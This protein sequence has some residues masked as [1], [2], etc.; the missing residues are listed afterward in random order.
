MVFGQTIVKG[1]NEG[2]QAFIVQVKDMLMRPMPGV[3][4]TDMGVKFGLNGVD[5]ATVSFDHVRI[6]R[7]NHMNKY[8]DVTPEGE[9]VCDIKRNP[10]RFF[11]TTERLLSGRMCIAALALGCSK[12]A[13]YTA[14]KYSQIRKSIGPEGESTVP[15]FDY[16]LQQNALMPLLARTIALQV[17]FNSSCAIFA[18]PVGKEFELLSICC[19]TKTMMGWNCERVASVGR[20]RC[21]GMGYL[22]IARF[23]EY[24]A[25]AHAALTA[26]GDN[27]VLMAKIVKDIITDVTKNGRKL[28]EAKLNVKTQIGTFSD[29]TQLDT[30]VDLLRFREKTL[31]IRL[32][33]RMAALKK[34]GKSTFEVMMRNVSDNIQDLAMAYGERLTIESCAAV[35]SQFKNAENRKV[36]EYVFRLFAMETVKQ[37]LGFYLV[38]GAVSRTAAS[39]LI[40][41]EKAVVKVVAS[42]ANELLDSLNIMSDALYTPLATDYER[43]YSAPNYGEVHGAR[44]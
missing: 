38:E 28:P 15:I 5:N 36:F 6:P 40:E 17:Q 10:Q 11:K 24:I 8:A 41:T 1:K 12:G 34:S 3:T 2:V 4:I 43:Y 7:E 9:F 39:A 18:N 19:I 26:E 22:A 21:G 27:R 23:S 32:T 31:F 35:L 42:H 16:Q 20:E 44:L 37:N 13:I 33:T 29:V 30:L 14:L 25:M